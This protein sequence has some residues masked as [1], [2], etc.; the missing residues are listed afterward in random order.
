[1]RKDT[2]DLPGNWGYAKGRITALP[3]IFKEERLCHYLKH[4]QTI[5]ENLMKEL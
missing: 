3:L 2:V 1:M 5:A 4:S